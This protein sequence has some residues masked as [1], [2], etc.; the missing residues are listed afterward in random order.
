MSE[1]GAGLPPQLLRGQVVMGT[2]TKL[3]LAWLPIAL[4]LSIVA[5]GDS[6][7]EDAP[8]G[9]SGPGLTDQDAD[10]EPEDDSGTTSDAGTETD[11]Q[12]DPDA[13]VDP[14]SG[15]SCTGKDGC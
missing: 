2:R 15:T 8:P 3:T 5:C 6:K 14:D 10:V 12:V 4:G 7:T 9:D 11:A 1:L 13:A